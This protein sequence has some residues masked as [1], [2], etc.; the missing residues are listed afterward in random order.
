MRRVVTLL[1]LT[2]LFMIGCDHPP[3]SPETASPLTASMSNSVEVPFELVAAG[4]FFS[5]ALSADGAVICW[6]AN[7]FG[8]LGTGD[9]VSATTPQPV[10]GEVS[11]TSLTAAGGHACALDPDGSAFCWGRNDVGQLGATT[12]DAC[13]TAGGTPVACSPRPVLVAGGLRF[14]SLDVGW[15]HSCG[16]T[17]DGTAYCWGWNEFGQLGAGSSETCLRDGRFST[18]CSRVPLRL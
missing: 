12:G 15:R 8:S 2:V 14:E 4:E 9:T 18:P 11:F 6:G 10:V 1:A 3:T 7:T 16:L 5:C 13:S 17:E